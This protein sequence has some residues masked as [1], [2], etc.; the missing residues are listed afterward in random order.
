M[1][2]FCILLCLV[3]ALVFGS[4]FVGGNAQATREVENLGNVSQVQ[5]T[6]TSTPL[7]ITPTRPPSIMPSITATQPPFT[8]PPTI[9]PSISPTNPPATHTPTFAPS[10]TPQIC[11]GQFFFEEPGALYVFNNGVLNGLAFNLCPSTRPHRTFAQFATF[12]N[13]F[14]IYRSDTHTLY[15]FIDDGTGTVFIFNTI[16]FNA[17]RDVSSALAGVDD[18]RAGDVQTALGTPTGDSTFYVMT[19]QSSNDP[20]LSWNGGT[21]MTLPS[22]GRLFVTQAAFS[23]PPPV[24]AYIN[25]IN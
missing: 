17:E 9:L 25:R 13:G 4:S 22:G 5:V 12:S 24:W 11:R 6:S 2:R 14:I 1:K 21:V 15:V 10:N 7:P 19:F 23:D 20:I 8:P 16:S 18:S 3:V